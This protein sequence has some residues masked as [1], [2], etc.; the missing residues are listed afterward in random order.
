MRLPGTTPAAPDDNGAADPALVEA[1]AIGD[2]ARINVTL[3]EARLLV[4]VV[5]MPS[6]DGDAE[7]AVPA[8]VAADGRR[9]LPVFS[10]YDA[11]RAWR[12]DARPV[13]MSGTRVIAGAVAERYDGVVLDVAGPISHT[14]D[15]ADLE[16]L[17]RAATA[18]LSNPDARIS[19][20]D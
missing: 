16:T 19:P 6:E 13:P 10:S 9:A 4:P 5:A 18:Y 14:V 3:L 8:L 7:M 17:A 20:V 1:L 15:D 11:L 12:P 2:P